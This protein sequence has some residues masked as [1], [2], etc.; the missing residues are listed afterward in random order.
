MLVRRAASGWRRRACAIGCC[1]SSC[2]RS[3]AILRTLGVR[4][5]RPSRRGSFC[6]LAPRPNCPNWGGPGMRCGAVGAAGTAHAQLTHS[7]RTTQLTHHARNPRLSARSKGMPTPARLIAPK[8]APDDNS[9]SSVSGQECGSQEAMAVGEAPEVQK[10]GG[11]QLYFPKGEA[12]SADGQCSDAL[13]CGFFGPSPDPHASLPA[14]QQV[15][16]IRK[17][18][19]D[20]L[21][22]QLSEGKLTPPRAP[23]M[24]SPS[25]V[26]LQ[27]SPSPLPWRSGDSP[28]AQL[29]R[30]KATIPPFGE[31]M[32]WTTEEAAVGSVR[33][34]DTTTTSPGSCKSQRIS[35]PPE[36]VGANDPVYQL[37]CQS[38]T[39]EA[40]C[41]RCKLTGHRV[42]DCPLGSNVFASTKFVMFLPICEFHLAAHLRA[43]CCAGSTNAKSARQ[44]C[45]KAKR[46]ANSRRGHSRVGTCTARVRCV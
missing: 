32:S 9:Q 36:V 39:S 34:L 29:Q 33:P 20:T 4:Q 15:S 46:Y 6:S 38:D 13:Q 41:F 24:H 30:M 11:L 31:R 42:K 40:A 35:P 1:S 22:L 17:D 8:A 25:S 16:M 18:N 19:T 3:T 37:I 45:S 14:A 44:A 28:L 26:S 10:E 2:R 7:S 23:Q 5:G 43:A 21:G 27:S 12:P